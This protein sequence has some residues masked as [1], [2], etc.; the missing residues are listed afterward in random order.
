MSKERI[1]VVED[2]NIVAMDIQNELR[3]L[4]YDVPRIVSTG[5]DAMNSAKE[6][7]P[8]LILM[9]IKI[10]GDKDGIETANDIWNQLKIPIIFL[11]AYADEKTLQRAKL[12]EPFGYVLKPFEENELHTAIEIALKKHR[13]VKE[14][15]A[16]QQEALAESEERFKLLI[17]SI[18]DYAIIMLDKEGRIQ[19]WN[20]GA[21]KITGYS[22]REV[23]GLNFSLLFPE[24]DIK[25][26]LPEKE[27]NLTLVNGKHTE[28]GWRLKKG[29]VKFWAYVTT[30]P[31]YDRYGNLKGFVKITRDMT[32][33]KEAETKMEML[34]QDVQ[35]AL[36]SREEFMSI[37]SHE[38]K[39]P[40]TSLLLQ[41]QIFEKRIDN[42]EVI[43]PA[44]I[45]KII[46][47]Y[48]HEISRLNRLVNDMLDM[49]RI[50]SGK[51]QLNVK[52]SEICAFTERVLENFKEVF[53]KNGKKL[54]I[55]R[56]SPTRLLIDEMRIEQVLGNIF[57]NAIRYAPE[58]SVDLNISYTLNKTVRIEIQDYGQGIEKNN[59]E[60]IFTRFERGT[61]NA[62]TTGL[63]LGLYISRQIINAHGGKIW[64][65][66][67]FGKG[68]KFI[69]ELPA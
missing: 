36:K 60:K 20:A 64:A 37:A 7:N 69:I 58:S 39:T 41:T 6:L 65:E 2:E 13:S 24:D 61:A 63:G 52:Q 1:L 40:L 8:D 5:E 10:K 55:R 25:K 12:A 3:G 17:E 50:H 45:K 44:G 23:S 16:K 46:A 56:C 15:E 62:D 4:G 19:S 35:T 32:E 49:T 22:Q 26:G 38:L 51:L 33:K 30:S 43:T 14:R 21:E 66:S 31:L 57:S 68:T 42:N 29:R 48:K 11:T 27:L 9:D 18:Q 34:L 54:N 53:E 28:E 47:K 67:E 59:L